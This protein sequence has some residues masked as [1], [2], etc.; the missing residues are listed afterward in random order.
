MQASV[1]WW[2]PVFSEGTLSQPGLFTHF[3]IGII[4]IFLSLLRQHKKQADSEI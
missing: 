1:Q 2:Y 3:Y 4:R